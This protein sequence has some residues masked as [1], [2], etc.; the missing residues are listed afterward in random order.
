MALPKG[1]GGEKLVAVGRLG[2]PHGVRGELRLD[3][4]GTMPEG[5]EGYQTFFLA[6]GKGRSQRVE[7]VEIARWRSHDKLLL[8]TIDG[9]GD[10]DE[11][12]TYTGATLLVPRED[13]PP[14]EQGEYY[15]ADLMGC[16]VVDEEGS[17]LG[18][19]ADV[20][21]WGDYDMLVIASGTKSWM[22]PVIDDYVID[23]KLD[24]RRVVVR[25]PEGLGP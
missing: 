8:V 7:P 10:R 4:L 19:V 12:A 9:A 20:K 17:K 21:P 23:M 25:V 16:S 22:L 15:H 3:H 13:L 5:L 24:R 18:S 11:A 2:R 14:L 1:P 6:R